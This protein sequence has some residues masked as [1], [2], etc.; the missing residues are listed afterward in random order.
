LLLLTFGATARAENK[1]SSGNVAYLDLPDRTVTFRD[2]RILHIDPAAKVFINGYEVT[3]LNE[4]RP[5]VWVPVLASAPATT[6]TTSTTTIVQGPPQQAAAVTPSG[7]VVLVRE[8]PV[9]TVTETTTAPATTVA[10]IPGPGYYA[11]IDEGDVLLV[12]YHQ[13]P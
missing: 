1:D 9:V 10:S 13:A 6:T 12:R 11:S 2:G 4:V 5:G 8:Y 3:Q 7:G